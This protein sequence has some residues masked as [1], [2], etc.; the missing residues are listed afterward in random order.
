MC[1]KL[2]VDEKIILKIYSESLAWSSQ[3]SAELIC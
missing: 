3:Q 2:N 1:E